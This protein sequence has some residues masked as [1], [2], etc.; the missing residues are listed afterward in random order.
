[1]QTELHTPL[2]GATPTQIKIAKKKRE[3]EE[4]FALAAERLAQSK[5]MVIA[6]LPPEPS[7]PVDPDAAIAEWVERQ[8]LLAL[9]PMKAPWFHIIEE[10]R[11]GPRRPKIEEI[12]RCTAD[13][14]G[15]TRDDIICAR[16]TA[17]IV[18]PRQVA[19]YL[20]KELTLKSFPEI[21]RMFG[22]R[23]HTTALSS[24]RKIERLLVT[25]CELRTTIERIKHRL[26][27]D[28]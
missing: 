15:C 20:C 17:D 3:R 24:F 28:Q 16:R 7:A 5:V 4:R 18:L 1:M 22:G 10:V 19:V 8:K 21:G 26:G 12:Q 9:S 25:D 6:P 14:F 23:D 11:T 27:G 13:E 2:R